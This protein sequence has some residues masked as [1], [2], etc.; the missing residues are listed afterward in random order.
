VVAPISVL[1]SVHKICIYFG[2]VFRFYRSFNF[3]LQ[4]CSCS[5]TEELPLLA[6]VMIKWLN[7][8]FLFYIANSSFFFVVFGR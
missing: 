8:I 3:W 2:E 6:F 4:P 1:K 5:I 7:I